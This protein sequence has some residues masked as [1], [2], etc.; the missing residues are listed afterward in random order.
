VIGLYP[1]LFPSDDLLSRTDS[2]LAEDGAAPALRRLVLESRDGV[3]RALRAQK[4][5]REAARATAQLG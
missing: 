3:A 1:G 5:D 2:W 4:R